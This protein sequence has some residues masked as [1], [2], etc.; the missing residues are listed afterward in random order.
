MFYLRQ[1][2]FGIGLESCFD[3]VSSFC[4]YRMSFMLEWTLKKNI[5]FSKIFNSVFIVNCR[6]KCFIILYFV[7]KL[8]I[9]QNFSL[10]ALLLT[11]SP[12]SSFQG[13][14][15]KY[16]PG[17][18]YIT[19]TAVLFY[20]QTLHISNVTKYLSDAVCSLIVWTEVWT[21]KCY[22]LIGIYVF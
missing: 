19:L 20:C 7:R 9:L 8:V 21:V 4:F 10:P 2:N 17:P 15:W 1:S 11:F 3:F 18:F 13:T 22:V 5:W 12:G 6:S 14:S 16:V